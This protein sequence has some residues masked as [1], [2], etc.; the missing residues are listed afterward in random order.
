MRAF[1]QLLW[2]LVIGTDWLSVQYF[3]LI[4][5]GTWMWHRDAV[6]IGCGL[7]WA[8]G[9]MWGPYPTR[10]WAVLGDMYRPFIKYRKKIR[11]AV[12][13]RLTRSICCLGCELGQLTKDGGSSDPLYTNWSA[14]APTPKVLVLIRGSAPHSMH[15]SL[16]PL[17]SVPK[18]H[19]D[20][21]VRFCRD[22]GLDQHTWQTT[23][24]R[25]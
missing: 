24:L 1:S 14:H 22:H 2:P 10:K 11:W 4:G 6:Y 17:E 13:K 25:L 20:R 21:L 23:P 16:G 19:L 3:P 8:E 18:R 15:G 7:G 9:T 12:E 5:K